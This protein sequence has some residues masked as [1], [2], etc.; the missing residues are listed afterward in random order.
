MVVSLS[1]CRTRHEGT[2]GCQGE[3]RSSQRGLLYALRRA[4]RGTEFGRG[5][6]GWCDGDDGCRREGG[7]G[8]PGAA[9]TARVTIPHFWWL[10]TFSSLSRA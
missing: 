4:G 7:R 1:E 8:I 5:D 2:R 3:R 9:R 10:M 6:P